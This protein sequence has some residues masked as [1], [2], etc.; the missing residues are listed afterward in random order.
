MADTT[1]KIAGYDLDLID[2]VADEFL[3]Y[4]VWKQGETIGDVTREG[5]KWYLNGEGDPVDD[6]VDALDQLAADQSD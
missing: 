2:T 5:G 6:L 3:R 1:P 4:R